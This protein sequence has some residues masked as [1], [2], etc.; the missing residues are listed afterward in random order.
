MAQRMS[1]RSVVTLA[2]IA[3]VAFVAVVVAVFSVLVTPA[4]T[5]PFA[6]RRLYIY[7]DSSAARAAASAT[8]ADRAAVERIA[9]VPTAVWIT[10]E[11]HGTAAVASFVHDVVTGAS[12]DDS[13]PVL[14]VYGIPDR[15]CGG[16]TEESGGH[17]GGFSA[18]GL[19]AAEYPR[20]LDQI[21][22]GIGGRPAVIILEPD[23]LALASQCG[24]AD[25]R[26][27]LIS[28]AV[29]TL[30]AESTVI[31]LDGGHST[32][33]SAAEQADLL[34]RAGVARVRGFASNVSNYNTTDAEIGYDREIASILGGSHFVI[35]TG[36]N[37]NGSN[38]QWCNPT[39][40]AL[41]EAP[42][43]TGGADGHD[44]NLWIKNPGESDGECN[45][46]PAAGEWWPESALTLATG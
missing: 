29:D 40:R 27:T 36:R 30:S 5:D 20:W 25:S 46:G 21:A 17:A 9:S 12:E 2:I 26:V 3:T 45:G 39:G 4:S 38:G 15:D 32:W 33:R 8:G 10:P 35:D 16:D 7:P 42:A 22:S 43:A 14:V 34:K 41:G 37:G 23:S 31:Y 28:D 6:G 1:R 18:G 13:L 11:R 44:A 24:N 19:S